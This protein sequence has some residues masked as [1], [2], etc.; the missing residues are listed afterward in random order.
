MGQRQLPGVNGHG[1]VLR[2]VADG[3]VDQLDRR[4]I[5]REM[6]SGFQAFP[7]PGVEALDGVGGVQDLPDLLWVRE[8]G[9]DLLPGPVPDPANGGVFLA[10]GAGLEFGYVIFLLVR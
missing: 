3:Q 9:N 2:E 4:F 7:Q 8:K 6:P 10:P 5:S 1:P